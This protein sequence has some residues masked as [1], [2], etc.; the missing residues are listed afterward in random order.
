MTKYRLTYDNSAP[1]GFGIP[2]WCLERKR[3]FGWE[4]IKRIASENDFEA[5]AREDAAQQV[6]ANAPPR[7]LEL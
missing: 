6:L 3:G 5:A 1:Q 2:P 7:Y 4:F